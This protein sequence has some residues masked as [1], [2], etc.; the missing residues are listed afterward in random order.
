MSAADARSGYSRAAIA[1]HWLMAVLILGNLAGGLWAE[2]L[3]E[4]A[5]PEQR[6]LGFEIIQLHKS[7]GL[8]VL[9]LTLARLALRLASPPPPLPAHMT[10]TERRLARI[11]HGG[12]YLL[13]LALPLSGWWMVS[14]SP[15]GLPTFW[16]GLF[17]WP[18][19]PVPGGRAAAEAASGVHGALGWAMVGLLALHVLAALKHHWLDRDDVLARMLP[20]V[21]RRTT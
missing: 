11:S 2:S 5:D 6:R 4:S 10:A 18:H 9:V 17:E 13:M 20:L 21:R 15:L 14:A 8:T 19:L 16:F 12:F 3:L 1:L 7:V